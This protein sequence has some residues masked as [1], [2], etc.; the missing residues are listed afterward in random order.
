MSSSLAFIS[1]EQRTS[2]PP[3]GRSAECLL[4]PVTMQSIVPLHGKKSEHTF[5]VFSWDVGGFQKS[6][7]GGKSN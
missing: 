4:A 6:R 2:R 1:N 7:W 5:K 3:W